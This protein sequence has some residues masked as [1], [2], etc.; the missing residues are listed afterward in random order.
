MARLELALVSRVHSEG[1]VSD[2]SVGAATVT[3]MLWMLVAQALFAGMN[4][5]TR[6]GAVDLP[7]PE[8]AAGRFAVGA[9]VAV[10]FAVP[11]GIPLRVIDR[12]NTWRRSIFGT[13]SALGVFYAL[14]SP[15]VSVGDAATLVATTPIFVALLS[16]PLLGERV[17]GH[18]GL[19]LVLAF[20]GAL[21]VIRPSFSSALPVAAAALAGAMCFALAII[22]LRKI[23]PHE[24]QPAIVLHYS[25]FAAT[26]MLLLALP[27]W[28]TPDLRTALVVAGTGLCGGLAQVAMTRA[29][30]Q[31]RAAPVAA[32]QYMGVVLT[33]VY[34]IPMFGDRP[35]IWQAAGALLVIAAGLLVILGARRPAET[36]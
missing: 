23:G 7:W 34:A 17:G 14:A 21:V 1:S 26:V 15:R 9:L 13:L 30:A 16:R 31:A 10:G 32:L 25:L 27:Q 5:L 24:S 36:A 6:L 28:R 22:W 4:V 29:F 20:L 8:V 35:S 33:Y 3:G 11:M 12:P 19:G 2:G 18:V